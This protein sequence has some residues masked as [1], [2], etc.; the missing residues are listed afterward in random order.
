MFWKDLL[1][2]GSTDNHVYGYSVQEQK[3]KFR[4]EV[5][6]DVVLNPTLAGDYLL[7]SSTDGTIWCLDLKTPAKK[8]SSQLGRTPST[9]IVVSPTGVHV[10]TSTG[11]I[12]TFDRETGEILWD[13]AAGNGSVVGLTH[14]GTRMLISLNTG[15]IAAVS[16]DRHMV[17]W[18]YQAGMPLLTSPLLSE[19]VLYI[20][21]AAGKIQFLGVLECGAGSTSQQSSLA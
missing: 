12:I 5:T 2:V 8:W 17:A 4:V 11:Q 13:V 7:G 16:L 18:D 19:G 3:V 15:K 21:G 1:L 9:P 6:S 10:G 20:G 14:S